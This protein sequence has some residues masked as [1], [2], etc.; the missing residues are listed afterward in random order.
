MQCKVLIVHHLGYGGEEMK[1]TT[2]VVCYPGYGGMGCSV[3]LW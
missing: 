1:Y 2:P 3:K